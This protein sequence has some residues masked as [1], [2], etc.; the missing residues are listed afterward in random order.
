MARK[1][2]DRSLAMQPPDAE[3]SSEVP[4]FRCYVLCVCSW[5]TPSVASYML[6]MREG[7]AGGP[8]RLC[9]RHA[10]HR[11]PPRRRPHHSVTAGWPS[12]K[13]TAGGGHAS[14]PSGGEN[15][16]SP[17]SVIPPGE[18]HNEACPRTCTAS[19]GMPRRRSLLLQAPSPSD[20][21]SSSACTSYYRIIIK[22]PRFAHKSHELEFPPLHLGF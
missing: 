11:A 4:H 5:S 19:M 20:H 3:L 14:T 13:P 17:S 15:A 22:R 18:R 9:P 12:N 6:E 10:R 1:V 16:P 8:A 7:R 2:F 21:T